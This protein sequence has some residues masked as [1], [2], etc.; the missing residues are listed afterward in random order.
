LENTRKARLVEGS[1]G[2]TLAR[3]TGPMIVGI[4][5]MVVFNLVDTFF[6]GQLGTQEL[7]ALSFTFPV[8]LLIASISMGLGV[9]ASSVVSRAIGEGNQAR[10]QRL[11]T[12]SLVLAVILAALIVTVGMLTIEPVFRLLG[13]TPEILELIKQYLMIWYP[14]VLFIMIPM[15]GN[16]AIRATGDTK[17]PSMVMLVAV[18][19]NIILDPL[20]IFGIGPFP[21]LEMAGAAIATVTARATTFA[22][23][24]WVLA[25]REKMLT[26]KPPKVL[27]EVI[28]SWKE[29]LYIG[30]PTAA[31]NVVNPLTIGVITSLVASY[32]AAAVAAYGAATRIDMFAMTVVMALS[33]VLAPFVGQNWGA[34]KYER[35]DTAIKYTHRFA[36]AWGLLLFVLLLLLGSQIAALFNDNPEVVHIMALYL[37][38]VSLGYGCHGLVYLSSSTLNVLRKPFH[39]AA[40][41]ALQMLVLYIPLAYLGSY[42]FGLV[43]IFVAAGIAYIIAGAFAYFWLRQFVRRLAGQA[44]AQP[45]QRPQQ[46]Q[47]A[48]NLRS[49]DA[50]R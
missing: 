6:V 19:V 45:P 46:Q 20:L 11:T 35:I 31:T 1:V 39:A 28:S 41:N 4:M 25:Y 36:L 47:Q 7:A 9:G 44:A 43:G 5:G 30:R 15:V 2:W 26:F 27:D 3:L 13:A 40:L 49:A 17:T 22:V 29:I 23:A 21:R 50:A 48:E 24:I 33:S 8:V 37:G 14:G 10:V 38:I 42:L 34:G 16:N 12:D 18:T 32:G